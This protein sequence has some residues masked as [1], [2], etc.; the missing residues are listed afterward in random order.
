MPQ[1]DFIIK[2]PKYNEELGQLFR[3]NSRKHMNS[4]TKLQPSYFSNE[5]E[6]NEEVYPKFRVAVNKAAI[7]FH[8]EYAKLLEKF[9]DDY[10]QSI[11]KDFMYHWRR[12]S[13]Y[14]LN[15]NVF[16]FG[17]S[18]EGLYTNLMNFV[19]F[20]QDNWN[21]RETNNYF[22]L[23]EFQQKFTQLYHTNIDKFT[24]HT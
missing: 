13:T 10:F 11:K 3:E 15:K 14:F 9:Y 19:E 23:V 21:T 6:Y 18:P 2:H 1:N 7:D 8:K 20:S 12:I 17:I 4:F 22:E 16:T 5:T 24:E